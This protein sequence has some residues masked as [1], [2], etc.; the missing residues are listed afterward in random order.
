MGTGGAEAFTEA[1]LHDERVA[2][3]RHR[4][5]LAAYEKA[6]PPPN[7]R[8][9][10]VTWSLRDGRTLSA[11]VK[12]PRGGADEPF[13][14]P[15]LLAKLED[16]TRAVLPAA[17]SVLEPII[18]GDASALAGSWSDAVKSIATGAIAP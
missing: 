17:R 5:T 1:A 13:D 11:F 4:V 10:H 18:A 8:P 12:S 6:G 9:G 16:N 7:D 3:L 14:E 15:T 2:R